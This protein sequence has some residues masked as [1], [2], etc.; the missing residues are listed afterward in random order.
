MPLAASE[1]RRVLLVPQSTGMGGMESFCANL[2]GELARRGIDVV[3]LVPEIPA[4]DLLAER[5]CAGGVRVIRLDTD[6]RAG[7]LGQVARLRALVRLL[8]SWRPEVI[9]IHTDQAGHGLVTQA[10]LRLASDAVVVQTEHEV[11]ERPTLKRKLAAGAIRAV[12]HALVAVSRQNVAVRRRQLPSPPPGRFGAILNGIPIR[13]GD[14]EERAANRARTRAELGIASD[15]AVIGSVVRLAEGKAI[16]VMLRAFA[17]MRPTRPCTLLL[18]GDGP[19]RPSLEALA[20]ELGIADRVCF[21]GFRADPL[22]YVDALDGFCLSVPSGSMSIALLE[23]MARG[24]PS[25]ITF[26]GPEE[27]VI[28]GETGLCAPPNDPAGLAAVLDRLVADPELATRLGE[29]G[30]AHV[31]RHFSI[32]RVADDHLALY[33]TARDGTIPAWLRADAPPN[34][35][36]GDRPGA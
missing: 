33:A 6:R 24:V 34:G 29:R 32:A 36:P 21:A 15:T 26:C 25:V 2:A 17:L 5:L 9:H 23:A 4:V 12:G 27:A 30:A 3:A 8:R 14:P 31:R 1:I 7:R 20:G 28:D 11:R 19:L 16:D 22:P 18:V 13:A 35:R 10:I